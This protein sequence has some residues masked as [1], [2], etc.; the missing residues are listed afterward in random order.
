[1]NQN[2]KYL[3]RE[4]TKKIAEFLKEANLHQQKILEFFVSKNFYIPTF[5][6]ELNEDQED[7]R[8]ETLRILLDEFF[9]YQYLDQENDNYNLGK[10]KQ[11]VVRK[12]TGAKADEIRAVLMG[13][14]DSPQFKELFKII[15]AFNIKILPPEYLG[16]SRGEPNSLTGERGE[17]S[18]VYS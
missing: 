18:G 3:V 16:G 4:A 7:W 17:W 11:L 12:N 14:L 9:P 6:S 15:A 5:K 2:N 13:Y 10:F 8:I 1:M